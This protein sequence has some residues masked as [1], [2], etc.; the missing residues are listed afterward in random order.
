MEPGDFVLWDSRTVHYGAAPLDANKRFAICKWR[1]QRLVLNL[2]VD[3]C[4]KP[5]ANI[6]PE[7]KARKVEAFKRGYCTSHDPTDFLVKDDQEAEWN[8]NLPYGPPRISEATE[9]AIGIR[10]Y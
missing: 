10:S 2:C 3:I 8:K 1:H 9:K 7:Q 5:D 4:Y 6:T